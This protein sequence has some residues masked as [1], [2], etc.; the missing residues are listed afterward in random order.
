MQKGYSI[1]REGFSL[2]AQALAGGIPITW[3]GVM[4]GEGSP[5][6]GTDLADMTE[7]VD[8]VCAGT[9]TIPEYHRDRV[10]MTI[11]YRSDLNGGVGRDLLIREWGV[12]AKLGT[13]SD[14]EPILMVYG[15]Q[16]D[17]PAYVGA[18]TD[19]AR[20]IRRWPITIRVGPGLAFDM[21]YSPDAFMTAQDIQQYIL[22]YVL[23]D[24]TDKLA[25][26]I[27]IHNLDP[28]SHPDLRVYIQTVEGD[29]SRLQLQV[30]TGVIKNPFSVT[31][32]TL[33]GVD[34]DGVWLKDRAQMAFG[35]VS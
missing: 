35:E 1:T 19:G 31:F 30:G 22:F 24:L 28:E 26:L 16:G 13:E 14:T 6:D 12:Y 32:E 33:D 10:T 34:V 25:D 18:F 2:I 5:V 23:P 4:M 20:D 29:L 9:T 15:S 11:E 8:P 7:L 3:M 27:R 21:G 17:Y